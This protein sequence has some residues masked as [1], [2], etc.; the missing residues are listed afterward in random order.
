MHVPLIDRLSIE[1]YFNNISRNREVLTDKGL[2]K[3][4]KIISLTKKIENETAVIKTLHTICSDLKA[5]LIIKKEIVKE[6]NKLTIEGIFNGF[7]LTKVSFSSKDSTMDILGQLILNLYC[8]DLHIEVSTS[9][10]KC[11]IPIYFSLVS[12]NGLPSILLLDSSIKLST[13]YSDDFNYKLIPLSENMMTDI[14]DYVS[15]SYLTVQDCLLIETYNKFTHY[16][17]ITVSPEGRMNLERIIKENNAF[18]NTDFDIFFQ[19]EFFSL[20][21]LK[22][23]DVIEESLNID[24][25]LCI[26]EYRS[27]DATD[28]NEYINSDGRLKAVVLVTEKSSRVMIDVFSDTESQD[29]VV[30]GRIFSVVGDRYTENDNGG[31]DLTLEL[32]A[33]SEDYVYR[34]GGLEMKPFY[35][36]TSFEETGLVKT[37]KAVKVAIKN[38]KKLKKQGE[39]T[40]KNVNDQINYVSTVI[41]HFDQAFQVLLA[42]ISTVGASVFFGPLVGVLVGYIVLTTKKCKNFPEKKKELIKIYNK[43]IDILE[44]AEDEAKAVHDMKKALQAKKARVL[45][46][47][48]IEKLNIEGTRRKKLGK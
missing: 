33:E 44:K 45:Y 18:S 26:N 28:F 23:S 32:R 4:G 8:V 46:E 20:P 34:I 35:E 21:V 2:E 27:I 1:S 41:N 15:D 40:L 6:E 14:L 29:Y 10:T 24:K 38:C 30:N 11:R 13:G 43:H 19:K 31:Y 22:F 42:S 7:R 36:A 25:I 17:L 12:D 39:N 16:D 37:E 5:D 9:R 3:D 47:T 48:R